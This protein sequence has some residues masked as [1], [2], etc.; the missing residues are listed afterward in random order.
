MCYEGQGGELPVPWAGSLDETATAFAAAHRALYG[1]VL[2][3]PVKLVTIRIEAT[4][5]LAPPPR[6]LLP[7]GT[8]A[9]ARGETPVH[10]RR[11]RAPGGDL[12]PREPG[13]RRPLPG[14]GDRDQLDSTTLVPPGWTATMHETGSLLLRR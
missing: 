2:D 4:G 3:A 12:R 9:V 7:A 8:G 11:R 5:V 1:F 6:S 13:R 14:P 10:L